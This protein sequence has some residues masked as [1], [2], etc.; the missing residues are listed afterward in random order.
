MGR[1]GRLARESGGSKTAK[2][3]VEVET[4]GWVKKEEG[5]RRD[6]FICVLYMAFDSAL[7]SVQ[8]DLTELLRCTA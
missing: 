1:E 2:P 7:C 6:C 5:D 8:N 4:R 3:I